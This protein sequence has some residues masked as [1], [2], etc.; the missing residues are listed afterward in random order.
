MLICRSR[1]LKDYKSRKADCVWPRYLAEHP[2]KG[3]L[4]ECGGEIT[5]VVKAVDE[6]DYHSDHY[7]DLKI[8]LTCSRCKFP[9]VPGVSGEERS[10]ESIL[11]EALVFWLENK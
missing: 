7:A 5:V 3:P 2:E 6:P 10:K 4:S 8:E 11:E 1:I 9:F